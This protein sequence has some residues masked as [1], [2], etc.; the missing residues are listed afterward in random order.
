MLCKWDL[1][2]FVNNSESGGVVFLFH[3][4]NVVFAISSKWD[5]GGDSVGLDGTQNVSDWTL[6]WNVKFWRVSE[7]DVSWKD[8]VDGSRIVLRELRI[9][10]GSDGSLAPL[11]NFSF[12]QLNGNWGRREGKKN[13]YSALCNLF[14]EM[15]CVCV[16]LKKMIIHFT[17][18]F[19]RGR[20]LR[21]VQPRDKRAVPLLFFMN[22]L[23]GPSHTH[24]HTRVWWTFLRFELFARWKFFEIILAPK[25]DGN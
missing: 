20:D 12:I 21:S 18:F 14:R 16:C 24:T 19:P 11:T 3:L 13:V 2:V 25:F 6:V 23:F 10:C 8:A 7:F 5:A 22:F 15:L 17:F 4:W 9:T 1:I